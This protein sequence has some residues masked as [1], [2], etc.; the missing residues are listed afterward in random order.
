MNNIENAVENDQL[1]TIQKSVKSYIAW[2]ASPLPV[3]PRG[4][5]PW[6]MKSGKALNDWNNFEIG[7]EQVDDVFCSQ[8]MNVGVL[9][10]SKSG[11]L[12]DVDLDT[13]EALA[14]APYFLPKTMTFGHRL[15]RQSHWLY[16]VDAP[17]T[18]KQFK[19]AEGKPLLELRGD[20]GQTVFPP[21]IHA[22]G[23]MISFDGEVNHALE[24]GYDELLALCNRL[25]AVTLLA[26]HWPSQGGRHQ[27]A[28]NL[29]G[30][31]A[32]SGVSLEDAELIV[33]MAAWAAHDEEYESRRSDVKSTYETLSQDKPATG[34]TSLSKS[35]GD[36]VV[37][38]VKEWL[39]IKEQTARVSV[40]NPIPAGQPAVHIEDNL[41][42][43]GMAKKFIKAQNGELL[44][45]R[46]DEKWLTWEK[47]HW[48]FDNDVNTEKRVKCYMEAIMDMALAAKNNDLWHKIQAKCIHNYLVGVLKM[49]RLEDNVCVERIELDK[50]PMLL[51]FSNGTF[52][53][54][55]M[56][57]VDS[58][59]EHLITR[60]ISIAFDGKEMCP[61][62]DDFVLRIM[63]GNPD[64]VS[65]LQRAVGYT[66][67]GSVK[68][69]VFFFLYGSGRNGKSTFLTILEKLVGPY[70]IKLSANTLSAKSIG[71]IP[72]DIARLY[73]ARLAVLDEVQQ[74]LRLDEAK[75]KNITGGDKMS[76]RFLYR[77]LFD[78]HT[79]AKLW[80]YGNHKPTIVGTD[81]GIW[82]RVCLIPFTVTIPDHE[83]D[84]D[85]PEKLEGELPG[86]LRWAIEGC[87]LWKEEGLNPPATVKDAVQNYRN[88][89][90]V[91]A[92]FIKDECERGVS[93]EV[94]ATDLYTAYKTY[95]TNQ[96]EPFLSQKKFGERMTSLDF[97]KK[98]KPKIHYMGI[99][100]RENNSDIHSTLSAH[101]TPSFS[102]SPATPS[103]GG[104]KDFPGFLK[105]Q[106][107][108]S[109]GGSQDFPGFLKSQ[110]T[111]SV[112]GSQDFPGFLKSQET[113]SVGGAPVTPSVGGSPVFNKVDGRMTFTDRMHL[114]N[115][116]IF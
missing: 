76:G 95:C 61:I 39:G 15:K 40:T 81:H 89:E 46:D 35:M 75:I 108:P 77:E 3:K 43:H 27:A 10:G 5:V 67:T 101:V 68:E 18:T 115:G 97:D 62:W 4:K 51:T 55:S 28:L 104:S 30:G 102:G 105:S 72:N 85:L 83:V 79:S 63:G 74:N 20:G 80:M 1:A 113:R 19:V 2:G 12:M 42:C 93:Y 26:R 69:Q 90:D 116:D 29:A 31:L 94:G 103:V 14:L 84:Q 110:E 9:L 41:T 34:W 45:C 114:E 96:G 33:A 82:R 16:S 88:E 8:D 92:S 58:N 22:E 13:P 99:R 44:Y 73:G 7:Q 54:D 100:K 11:G 56:E 109:V 53:L 65:F 32:R 25:A 86:I 64:M 106:E 111:P 52:D 17:S 24:I 98:P 49:A 50:K 37:G 38:K 6:D 48:Q 66:L 59:P 71:G 47:T 107:T 57:F 87:K 91:V 36:K 70:G 78:F 60:M 21:S 112:G 23:G